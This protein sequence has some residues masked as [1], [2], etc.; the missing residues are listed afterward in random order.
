MSPCLVGGAVG[1]YTAFE[2]EIPELP[3]KQQ[4]QQQQ[5][6]RKRRFS[7]DPGESKS[8]ERKRDESPKVR[9]TTDSLK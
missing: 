2:R 6:Q 9:K 4:Q 1:V 5:Q 8:G 3:W 7:F